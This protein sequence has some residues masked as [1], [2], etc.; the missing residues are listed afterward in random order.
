VLDGNFAL[1]CGPG[2]DYHKKIMYI[3]QCTLELHKCYN[4]QCSRNNYTRSSIAHT[5]LYACNFA[6]HTQ[7]DRSCEK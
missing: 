5:I 6:E 1:R 4:E 3:F 7:F 2:M